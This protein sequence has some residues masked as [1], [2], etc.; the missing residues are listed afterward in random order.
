VGHLR[1]GIL[2]NTAPWRRVV[3]CL[4]GGESAAIV[5]QAT[6]EAAVRGLDH[7][8][9]DPAFAH[10]AY[11][12]ARVVLA[13]RKDDFAE[14]LR[15]V[16]ISVSGAPGVVDL[17]TAFGAA[18]D[19]YASN[20]STSDVGEMARLAAVESLTRLLTNRAGDLFGA[21]PADV[22]AAARSFSTRVGFAALFHDYFSSFANRFL[23]YHLGREL[24]LHV[25]GNGRF[26]DP[27]Q[28]DLFLSDLDHHCR[29]AALIV[30]DFAGDW[31]SK[32][33]FLGG[34][35]PAKARGFAN[36]CLTKLRDELLDRGRP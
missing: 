10:T 36:H 29:Q 3:G 2:P 33:N 19:S 13:A 9:D 23:T 1:T 27:G 24:S 20:R 15:T 14:A 6:T 4:A 16:G 18:V 21:G 11:L 35:S 12:L 31:Y 7:A 26:A 17:A 8:Y 5:A 30:R 28:H 32:H 34:I 22:Q 25:G